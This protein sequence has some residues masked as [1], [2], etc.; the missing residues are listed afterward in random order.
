[1]LKRALHVWE[2]VLGPDHPDV[3][4]GL[5]NLAVVYQKRGKPGKAGPLFRR[6][7]AIREKLKGRLPPNRIEDLGFLTS[8]SP[9]KDRR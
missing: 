6:A 1:M 8:L 5:E 2:K 4:T 9:K 3:A 7:Q